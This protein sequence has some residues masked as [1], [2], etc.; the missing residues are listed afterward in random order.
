MKFTK[1]QENITNYL[2]PFFNN[3]YF[4]CRKIS[5]SKEKKLF[6]I[7]SNILE[8]IIEGNYY[9][10]S[11]INSNNLNYKL[12]NIENIKHK[13]DNNS[14]FPDK[15][16]DYIYKNGK[17]YLTYSFYI[18]NKLINIHFM[19]FDILDNI[20][21]SKYDDYVYYMIIWLYICNKYSNTNILHI[22]NY[23]NIYIYLTPFKKKLPKNKIDILDAINVNTG[24]TWRSGSEICIFRK[25]NWFK[26][27]IH[28]TIHNYNYD[29]LIEND[30]NI[31]NNIKKMFPINIDLQIHESYT[32]IMAKLINSS[33]FCYRFL[34]NNINLKKNKNIILKDIIKKEKFFLY[35]NFMLTLERNYLLHQVDT[36]LSY[37]NLN[38]TDLYKKTNKAQILRDTLY[39]QNTH[40]FEYYII[41][42]ILLN[43]Y[44]DFCIWSSEYSN[45]YRFSPLSNNK[46]EFIKLIKNNYKSEILLN[47]LKLV[48]KFKNN[49][50]EKYNLLF[51][52]TLNMALLDF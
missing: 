23:K 26:T 29:Y 33:I 14:Y 45:F 5:H 3:S 52:N 16:K 41:P 34:K 42:C 51:N 38:Y 39:K 25:E 43:N 12:N 49:Y 17:K 40:V 11:L 35:L 19:L 7:F 18:N 48:K 47:D 8:D 28:E 1:Y 15:I 10:E 21:L 32:E 37:M 6:N 13:L 46:D 22:D 24:Y 2:I 9:I 50:T 20:K 31:I 27:F 36:I 30:S 4:N 44:N